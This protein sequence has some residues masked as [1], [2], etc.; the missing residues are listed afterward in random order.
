MVPYGKPYNIF[1]SYGRINLGKRVNPAVTQ[2]ENLTGGLWYNVPEE[3]LFNTYDLYPGILTEEP[4][5]SFLDKT[6]NKLTNKLRRRLALD[7]LGSPEYMDKALGIVGAAGTGLQIASDAFDEAEGTFDYDTWNKSQKGIMSDYLL[8]TGNANTTNDIL[9][10]ADSQYDFVNKANDIKTKSYN[11][12]K[13]LGAAASGAAAGTAILPGI[14]TAVGA[15]IGFVGNSLG[16]LFGIAKDSNNKDKALADAEELEGISTVALDNGR[17]RVSNN[18]Y[19]TGMA[20]YLNNAAFGGPLNAHGADF[21]DDIIRID[22]GGSHGSNPY[23]GVPAGKDPQGTPNLV[24]EGERIW[25]KEDYVFSDRLKM[26]KGL[27]RKYGLGGRKSKPISYAEGVDKISEKLGTELR[28]NDPITQRTR[29]AILTD[30]MDEQEE[31]RLAKEQRELLKAMSEMSPDEFSAM[32]GSLGQQQ[33]FGMYPQEEMM[34]PQGVNDEMAGE[35]VGLMPSGISAYGGPIGGREMLFPYDGFVND[36]VNLFARGGNEDTDDWTSTWSLAGPRR[37]PAVGVIGQYD[38]YGKEVEMHKD[39]KGRWWVEGKLIGTDEGAAQRYARQ[40]ANARLQ[41]NA[42]EE[43]NE[44][45]VVEG[46]YLEGLFNKNTRQINELLDAN[47]RDALNQAGLTLNDTFDK[48][49]NKTL[50]SNWLSDIISGR[51]FRNIDSTGKTTY[52]PLTY[53]DSAL[54]GAALNWL[55]NGNYTDVTSPGTY[56][57]RDAKVKENVEEAENAEEKKKEDA[58]PKTYDDVVGVKGGAGS[59]WTPRTF[60]AEPVANPVDTY[61]S[62]SFMFNPPA[63]RSAMQK[64]VEGVSSEDPEYTVSKGAMDNKVLPTW[65]RYAPIIG[66]GISVLSDL[67]DRPD[68]SGAERL[69]HDAERLGRPVTIPVETIG[70]RI[71]RNPFD[72]RL[73]VNQ[74]NQ[75]FLAALRSTMDTSGGNRAYRQYATSQLARD[76]QGAKSEIARNAY[77]ANRQDALQTADFNRGTGIQN[78]N[79]IN[80]RNIE[81]AQLNSNRQAQSMSARINAMNFLENLRRMDDQYA[82]LDLTNFL[83]NLGNLG[84]ENFIWNQIASRERE[85]LSN[86]SYSPDKNGVWGFHFNTNTTAYGGKKKTKKRRF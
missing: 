10:L 1:D 84:N 57:L 54:R 3:S 43:L 16:Q 76:N 31:K 14:G 70:D 47:T 20:N 51:A 33:P 72:E 30:F 60:F 74:A 49:L 38:H 13:S 86:V 34:A 9:G 82:S 39:E 85:G 22:A 79:A 53:G 19:R 58:K 42:Q 37:L 77:L 81:Q 6:Q 66:G 26:S 29:D 80:Q 46:D 69:V 12:G 55:N 48:A 17:K 63:A 73:A 35:P 62:R 18:I 65:M 75:N 40:I 7:K 21:S 24:E 2:L 28:P 64:A 4:D 67:L 56:G 61:R 45:A 83:Q 59:S 27:A 41:L 52:S 50:T 8:R 5:L 44:P 25:D 78:M 23:G 15:G 71:R 32:M 11:F 36:N 68:Y